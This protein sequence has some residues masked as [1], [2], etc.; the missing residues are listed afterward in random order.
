MKQLAG[1]KNHHQKRRETRHAIVFISNAQ[2]AFLLLP[3]LDVT[4]SQ[5]RHLCFFRCEVR[6]E[7]MENCSAFPPLSRVN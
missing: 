5:G 7:V 1:P 4:L 2:I 6:V 3:C